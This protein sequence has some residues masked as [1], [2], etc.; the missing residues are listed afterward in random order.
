MGQF[1]ANPVLLLDASSTSVRGRGITMQVRCISFF[2]CDHAAK[3]RW[4]VGIWFPDPSCFGF[5]R[6]QQLQSYANAAKGLLV[7]RNQNYASKNSRSE[8]CM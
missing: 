4:S 2:L 8:E 5:H 7:F 1:L 3:V 6:S